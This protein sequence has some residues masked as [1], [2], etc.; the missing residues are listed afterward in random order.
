M[1][2]ARTV[3]GREYKRGNGGGGGRDET[4]F[5]VRR[6]IEH[7]GSERRTRRRKDNGGRIMS[8]IQRKLWRVIRG[9]MM[10]I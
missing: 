1:R 10:Q 6:P 7:V 5:S 9:G 8:S 2:E 4:R 3:I